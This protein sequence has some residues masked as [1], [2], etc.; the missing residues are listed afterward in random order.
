MKT[1]QSNKS[2]WFGCSCR[3]SYHDRLGLQG[4]CKLATSRFL[5]NFFKLYHA[6]TDSPTEKLFLKEDTVT[7]DKHFALFS[8]VEVLTQGFPWIPHEN[9]LI[10]LGCK[11]V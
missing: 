1:L 7:S 4:F 11:L 8:V 10:R 2:S 5:S 6:L 9:T 3:L